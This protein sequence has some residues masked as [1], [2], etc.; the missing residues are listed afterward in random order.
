VK[1]ILVVDDEEAVVEFVGL[2]LEEAD[3]RIL[4][5]YDGRS[6][7]ELACNEHPDLVLSDIMMPILSGLEFC[8][9][10]REKPETANIPIILMTAGRTVDHACPNAIVLTK[11]FDLN[12]LEQ[13][14]AEKLTQPAS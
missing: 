14:V 9:L 8:R 13:A 11:P 5:A 3:H 2:L 1:T 12:A 10:L 6:A 4:R 7:F